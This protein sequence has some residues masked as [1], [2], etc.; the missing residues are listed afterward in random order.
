MIRLKDIAKR[1]GVSVMT[2]SKVLR[3]APD[4]SAATKNRIKGLARE[5]GY[6]PDSNARSLRT[7]TTRFLGVVISATTNPIF[8]RILL[9]IEERAHEHGFE[10]ILAHTLNREDREEACIRRLLARRVDGIFIS[11]V[12][13]LRPDAPIY[14][15]LQ[16]R[17]T[18]VVILGHTAHFCRQFV[19]V[20]TD[21]IQASFAAAQHLLQLGHKNIA[22]FTGPQAAPWAHERYEGYR[23]ALREAGMDV[24]ERLVF[25]AGSSIEDGA[26][27]ALQ[28]MNE[29]TNAT[30]I[31]T[32]NDMVAVGCANAFLNQG[33]KIPDHLS[34]IGFGNVLTSEYFR[35]P[36]TTVRQPK[37]RLGNIAMDAMLRLLQGDKAENK[38]LRAEIIIRQSTAP[39]PQGAN[40]P[41]G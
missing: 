19:N 23:R 5:M 7:R 33:I 34:V 31:Q 13:R 39:P 32:V 10:I 37:F 27:A 25:Q 22:F 17:G 28:F 21:D 30:A 24:E 4:I 20:E 38:R 36:L 40:T 8:A 1:A 35:V 3:D 16:A 41:A 26:N 29:S 12:Y 15:I 6:V 2:V 14:Q 9:A 18:P 11:P